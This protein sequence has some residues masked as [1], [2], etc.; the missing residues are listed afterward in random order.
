MSARDRLAQGES[1]TQEDYLG[2]L[3]ERDDVRRIHA[4][5]ARHCDVCIALS[6]TGAAPMGIDSTG[7]PIFVAPA[8]LLGTP[9]LNMPVMWAEGLPLGLQLIGFTN[10]DASMFAAAA[11]M[12]PLFDN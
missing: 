8:S 7:D 4:E 1:T 10:G 12:L 9:S 2:L 5:L 3:A 11:A 6:A